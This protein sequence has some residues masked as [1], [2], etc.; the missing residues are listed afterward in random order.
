VH[1]GPIYLQLLFIKSILSD[2]YKQEV[3]LP[4]ASSKKILHEIVGVALSTFA[5]VE[6]DN[7]AL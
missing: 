1:T 7:F 2:F 5:R 4:K 3:F 6:K